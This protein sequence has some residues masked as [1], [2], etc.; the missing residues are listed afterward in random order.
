MRYVDMKISEASII[1]RPGAYEY[2]HQVKLQDPNKQAGGM[3]LS[4]IKDKVPDFDP[5]E[6]LTWVEEVDGPTIQVGKSST[7]SMSFQR[8][9]GSGFTLVG[10]IQKIESGLNHAAGAK[11]STAENKGDLAEPLLSAAVVAKLIKRG[12]DSIEDI[13]IDDLKN[14]LNKAISTGSSSYK[15]A[16]KD[17]K[18]SD[19]I[20]FK[21]SIRGPAME[22]LKSKN[23]WN[24]MNN[25]AQSAV[26]Y[27]NSGQIDRYADYFFKN[28][29]ADLIKVDS[30]GL[31][32]QK[33]RKTDVDAYVKGSDG[34]LRPL[35]G[36]AISL[37][38]GSDTI[39]QVG[40]GGLKNDGVIIAAKKLFGPLGIDIQKPSE[41]IT[42]KTQ[43]WINAYNQANTQLRELLAG[44]DAKK[45]AGIIMKI[46]DFIEQQGSGGNPNVRLVSLKK[47]GLSSV[48]SFKNLAQKL[49]DQNVDLDSKIVLGKSK[50]RPTL[51][52]F[53]KNSGEW[54]LKIRYSIANEGT[55]KEK[56][57]NPIEMG[58]LIQRLTSMKYKTSSKLSDKFIITIKNKF[59]DLQ[60]ITPNIEKSIKEILN[61]LSVN[62]LRVVA[63][64]NIKFMSDLASQELKIKNVN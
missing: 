16:D 38:A 22:F 45:E 36:L 8:P 42:S 41:E 54:A 24:V 32:D 46:G 58:P 40:G 1:S 12:S 23:F 49:R 2:G 15:V 60:K 37:K 61:K 25:V 14:V 59:D 51:Y 47:S 44:Q 39:G 6:T 27:A 30:D 33:G 43:F 17:S 56:V 4:L 63:N 55:I 20:D 21:V 13:T 9:N 34:T 64:S 31:S 19:T 26:H 35:K 62:D 50:S 53:D 18:I 48:H 28:R 52:I 10:P 3:L 29:K 57:W 11:G 7:A 5:N